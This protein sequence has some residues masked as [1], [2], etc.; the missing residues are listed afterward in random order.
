MSLYISS[1]MRKPHC[2]RNYAAFPPPAAKMQLPEQRLGSTRSGKLIR[3]L[4]TDDA[5]ELANLTKNYR[6]EDHFDAYALFQFLVMKELSRLGA[7]SVHIVRYDQLGRYHK[8]RLTN[9]ERADQIV[10][11]SLATIFDVVNF[12]KSRADPIF[13]DQRPLRI[14]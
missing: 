11:L 6:S 12:G 10:K 8:K 5:D 4:L 13:H 3:Y 2:R 1:A 9:Q 14:K 7:D